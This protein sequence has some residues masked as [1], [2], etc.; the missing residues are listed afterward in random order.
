MSFAQEMRDFIGAYKA[1]S[2]GGPSDAERRRKA[3]EMPDDFERRHAA[4]NYRPNTVPTRS[5]TGAIPVDTGTS[6][7]ATEGAIEPDDLPEPPDAKPAFASGG[8]V[9]QG[10]TVDMGNSPAYAQAAPQE[11]LAFESGGIA[12]QDYFD[13]LE[14]ERG[15]RRRP[16]LSPQ[17]LGDSLDLFVKALS[18]EGQNGALPV[19]DGGQGFAAAMMG[20]GA[21]TPQEVRA[22]DMALDPRGRMSPDERAE[23]RLGAM[24][25]WKLQQ[26]D[27]RGA[28]EVA[29][30][31]SLYS[32]MQSQRYAGMARVAVAN[33]DDKGAAYYATK[34]A[35][36][37]PDGKRH[38][39]TPLGNGKFRAVS[40]DG[41][42]GKTAPPMTLDRAGMAKYAEAGMVGGIPLKA[43]MTT[44][45]ANRT[46]D[47]MGRA[48]RRSGGG[49]GRSGS[50]RAAKA[51][52]VDAADI[53]PL[54]AAK[55]EY[56][57]AVASGDP[58]RI[59]AAKAKHQAAY[60][61]FV[62]APT[63]SKNPTWEKGQ[64]AQRLNS[65]GLG[66]GGG[67]TTGG[68]SGAKGAPPDPLT[69]GVKRS[70][71]TFREI[72]RDKANSLANTDTAVVNRA[73]T[74]DGRVS[75][76][77][78]V[79]DA[80]ALEKRRTL[81]YNTA[82]AAYDNAKLDT[83][84]K[85]FAER[86]AELNTVLDTTLNEGAPD[87][88]GHAS[89]EKRAQLGENEK[90]LVKDMATRLMDKNPQM[91]PETAVRIVTEMSFGNDFRAGAK[92]PIKVSESGKVV[93]GNEEFLMGKEDITRAIA[94]RGKRYRQQVTD[95]TQ[96]INA[97][98]Q[99]KRIAD[100]NVAKA[101]A[102]ARA[103]KPV[104]RDRT[105]ETLGL[106]RPREE[107]RLG[108]RRRGQKPAEP[109]PAPDAGIP[110]GSNSGQGSA[111]SWD[112]TRDGK[113][114]DPARTPAPDAEIRVGRVR[115]RTR[116]GAIS[117]EGDDP[118]ATPEVAKPYVAS[119]IPS[120]DSI[121]MPRRPE[122]QGPPMDERAMRR[123][124]ELTRPLESRRLRQSENEARMD[125][126][127]AYYRDGAENNARAIPRYDDPTESDDYAP[128][129]K[130]SSPGGARNWAEGNDEA[131]R[132]DRMGPEIRDAE[133]EAP[134]QPEERYLL[135][136]LNFY[137]GA[138][139]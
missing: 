124:D 101:A 103:E 56:D 47:P 3:Q 81:A 14:Q 96:N 123:R 75:E 139:I 115:P 2:S 55:A 70:A 120:Y 5:D 8:V 117:V 118:E 102:E 1:V 98:A 69:E 46:G 72:E 27:Y 16:L 25:K 23:F 135:D 132:H 64:R 113:P 108:P 84:N 15:Q 18:A 61:A 119:G 122:E 80:A 129:D 95:N 4:E 28:M 88:S 37:L 43:L 121:E 89:T 74:P 73:R 97:G 31:L 116:Q 106:D 58:E 42:T 17:D 59:D 36:E 32:V 134:A 138:G 62:E 9:E 85:G 49:G 41:Y 130:P 136:D 7:P 63:S 137:T 67:S 26:G 94:E 109:V 19:D 91:S 12:H 99:R 76:V 127:E 34:A 105:R 24:V 107:E 83:N 22:M 11:R 57:A 50:G 68:T 114:D 44:A 128:L 82:G 92:L 126:G 29:K 51:P 87:K 112:F 125:P 30:A 20:R 133:R 71:G 52:P 65:L 93:L 111:G 79:N 35:Q 39:V 40:V 78:D 100:E 33:G 104:L 45:A 48:R 66:L 86:R 131:R 60:T 54:Q 10:L 90:L 13:R 53:A 21:A 6:A 38:V 77:L 110:D